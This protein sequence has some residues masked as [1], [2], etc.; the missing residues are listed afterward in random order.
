MGDDPYLRWMTGDTRLWSL[1]E[2]AATVAIV[3]LLIK[4][5]ALLS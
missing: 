3:V 2:L 5:A 1:I 4:G